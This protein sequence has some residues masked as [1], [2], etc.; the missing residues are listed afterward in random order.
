MTPISCGNL[1]SA[2]VYAIRAHRISCEVA[3]RVVREWL[4]QCE[5]AQVDPCRT[6][7]QFRCRTRDESFRYNHIGCVYELDRRKAFASQR[8]VIFRIEGG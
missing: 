4:S 2:F 5:P 6:T 3:R 8:V 7:S 1:Q